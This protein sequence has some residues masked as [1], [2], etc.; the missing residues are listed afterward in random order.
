MAQC[1]LVLEDGTILEGT[2]FGYAGTTYGEVV[3]N[4]GMTG[5][6]ESLTDPSYIGQI[7]IMS[8]PLI[9]NYG[10]NANDVESDRV[11][12]RGFAVREECREPSDGY[13]GDTLHRYLR[14]NRVPG[15][16]GID[17]R[18]LIIRI[19]EKGTPKGAIVHGGDPEA[20][21][22][23]L[24]SMPFP[25]EDNLVGMASVRKPVHF[26]RKGAKKVAL[27]DCGVKENILRELRRRFDLVQ[28]PYDTPAKFFRDN[29]IDGVFISNGPGDPGHP[30]LRRTTIRTIREI[31]EEYPIMGICMGNQLL[32]HAFGGGTYKMKFGHRGANQSVRRGDKVYITSQNHG[33]AV[34]P[35]SIEG[36]GL[37]VDQVNVNDGTVEGMRHNELPIVSSQYH[38]EACPGPRDTSFMFDDFA[39]MLEAKR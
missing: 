18:S 12:V 39:R 27:I 9:G 34:D 13:G 37:V 11:Q 32:A 20:V 2:G 7:L 36:S 30:D 8:Y 31:A 5:Y 26:E 24:R 14:E 25:S 4:T 6:Q 29:D 21:I 3:F 19:R 38:P 23:E 33:Y 35:S 15:I 22:K 1:F 16:S 28:L 17:T 10:V